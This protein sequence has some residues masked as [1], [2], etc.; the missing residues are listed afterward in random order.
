M[1]IQEDMSKFKENVE[2]QEVLVKAIS[3]ISRSSWKIRFKKIN[4]LNNKCTISS[5]LS[6]KPNELQFESQMCSNIES[7]QGFDYLQV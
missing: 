1:E 6:G 2:F 3:D 7:Q 4:A 5:L